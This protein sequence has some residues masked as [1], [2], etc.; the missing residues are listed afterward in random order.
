[1]QLLPIEKL[2]ADTRRTLNHSSMSTDVD[3]KQIFA[4]T[5]VMI[6]V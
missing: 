5:S 4:T 6:P 2:P 1:M 3:T